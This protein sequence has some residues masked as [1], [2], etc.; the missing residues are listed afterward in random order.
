MTLR[1][2]GREALTPIAPFPLR[3][4]LALRAL[5]LDPMVTDIDSGR[6]MLDDLLAANAEYLPQ[7][8]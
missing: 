4:E 2:C 1:M 8:G 3:A 5:L 7:F 6:A